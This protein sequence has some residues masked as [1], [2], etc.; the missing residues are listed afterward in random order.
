MRLFVCDKCQCVENTSLMNGDYKNRNNEYPNLSMMEMHG[1][2]EE[3]SK[4]H[5]RQPEYMLC[6]ECNTGTWHGEFNKDKATG[7]EIEMSKSMKGKVFSNHDLWDYDKPLYD[8]MT[9]ENVKNFDKRKVKEK[10]R[11]EEMHSK[12]NNMVSKSTPYDNDR[13]WIISEPYKRETPKIGRNNKCPCGS[14]KKYKKCCN[15]KGK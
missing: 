15:N 8:N 2:N 4:T 12:V 6:S 9:V 13:W 3:Y 5:I 1:F 11:T 14:D 7:I 10:S